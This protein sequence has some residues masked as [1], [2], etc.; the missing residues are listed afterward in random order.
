M[1]EE[2][3]AKSKN[4]KIALCAVPEMGHFIPLV[5]LAKALADRGHTVCFMAFKYHED[6][7]KTMI[8]NSELEAECYFAD[9]KENYT[10]DE[11]TQGIES[12]KDGVKRK[13]LEGIGAMVPNVK[14]IFKNHFRPD[15]MVS[16]LMGFTFY[17]AAD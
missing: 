12:R 16:D 10:R 1:I 17:M 6:K 8:K 9:E 5:R 11:I 15:I 2:R 14:E 13:M 7:I 4:L 3:V